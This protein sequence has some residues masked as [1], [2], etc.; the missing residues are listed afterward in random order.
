N[1]NGQ[2]LNSVRDHYLRLRAVLQRKAS[3]G[4]RSWR[5]RCRELLQQLS[6]KE[7]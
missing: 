1:W 2:Q 6:G 3:K 7:N 5:R 4:T